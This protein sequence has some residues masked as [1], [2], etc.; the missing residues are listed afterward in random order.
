MNKKLQV[1]NVVTFYQ[2]ACNF[3]PLNFSK[4]LLKHMDCC[5]TA[6][7]KK[8]CFFELNF[9]S[10][11]KILAG[12]ELNI[13]SE[14]EVHHAA[15][16]WVTSN[17]E[18]RSKFTKDIFLKIRTPLPSQDTLNGL[19]RLIRFGNQNVNGKEENEKHS[20]LVSSIIES[21]EEFYKSKSNTALT[22]RHCGHKMF[23]FSL[24]SHAEVRQVSGKNNKIFKHFPDFVRHGAAYENGGEIAW[25]AKR[26]SSETKRR[27]VGDNNIKHAG[28]LS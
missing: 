5:F 27:K 25:P 1:K 14:L 11:L 22:R 6:V 10:V 19:I 18:D 28:A 13:T 9:A 20:K 24:I 23:N 21:R 15:N 26:C 8:A 17:F 2:V 4:V 16:S 12:S 7:R 3:Q